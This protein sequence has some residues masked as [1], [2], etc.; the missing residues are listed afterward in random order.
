M[1]TKLA[2]SR[3]RRGVGASPDRPERWRL[4]PGRNLPIAVRVSLRS[5]T[6][7]VPGQPW[8]RYLVSTVLP[9]LV[10][11]PF[12]RYCWG[13]PLARYLQSPTAIQ[14]EP[15]HGRHREGPGVGPAAGVAARSPAGGVTRALPLSPGRCRLL[16]QGSD[17]TTPREARKG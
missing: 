15:A 16:A 7:D 10:S 14:T 4:I 6:A 9:P 8:E 12:S 11:E 13:V 1:R 5:G 3:S 17:R 2:L